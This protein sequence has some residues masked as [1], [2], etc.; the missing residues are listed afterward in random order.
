M[1]G[2]GDGKSYDPMSG[3]NGP[4]G[5]GVWNSD[6]WLSEGSSMDASGAGHPDQNGNYHY[7]ATPI[8]MYS[9]PSTSHS[10]IIGYAFDGFPMYGPFGYANPMD[11]ASA[12]KRMVSGYELRSITVRTILPDGS[13]ANPAGPVV[14]NLFPLGTYIED[15]EH[16]TNGDLDEYSGRSCVTPEYPGGTYAYFIS[17]DNNGD[18][19][20]P[21][22]LASEY[23]GIVSV[24]DVGVPAGMQTI[25]GGVSC[26]TSYLPEVEVFIIKVYPSPM[27]DILHVERLNRLPL[28]FTITDLLGRVVQFGLL[29]GDQTTIAVGRL[30]TGIY[31]LNVND[32][33]QLVASTKIIKD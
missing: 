7:H 2:Y 13:T 1:Y 6:A 27:N 22:L 9:D 10:P 23:Y 28:A 33:E 5:A 30:I 3:S 20:F 12:I 16:L 17:T 26:G 19:A 14:D 24:N 11:N 8:Q 25:P 29:R 21:Y 32:G 15:Y 31:F 18:P 4:M